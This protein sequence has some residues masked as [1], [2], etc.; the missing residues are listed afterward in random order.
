[1]F[2]CVHTPPPN[3]SRAQCV[4]ACLH[5]FLP[6]ALALGPE[7]MWGVW[8]VSFLRMWSVFFWQPWR[9]SWG[10][11]GV[12]AEALGGEP[13]VWLARGGGSFLVTAGEGLL[14]APWE[15]GAGAGW[16][17]ALPGA[18]SGGGGV[19]QPDHLWRRSCPPSLP[20]GSGLGGS[21]W[22]GEGT[23]PVCHSQLLLRLPAW[24]LG[25]GVK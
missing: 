22:H 3:L 25:P 1:M 21:T 5:F 19:F 15:L 6:L 12:W 24:P 17:L 2:V 11:P 7:C 18:V 13:G 16:L 10:Q 8:L 9:L 20:G 4:S 23:E 14:A